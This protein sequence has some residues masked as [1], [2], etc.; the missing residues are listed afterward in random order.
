MMLRNGIVVKG[1][2]PGLF[3]RLRRARCVAEILCTSVSWKCPE[4]VPV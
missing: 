3:R 4:C 2:T 1:A